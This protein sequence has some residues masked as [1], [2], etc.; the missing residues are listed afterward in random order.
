[1]YDIPWLNVVVYIYID[2][3][4]YTHTPDTWTYLPWIEY[5]MNLVKHTHEYG[6]VK[7]AQEYDYNLNLEFDHMCL[8][9]WLISWIWNLC[10]LWYEWNELCYMHSVI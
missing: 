8:A 4:I 1:M 3:Y 6:Y 10:T 5:A 7:Y 9:W 2:I